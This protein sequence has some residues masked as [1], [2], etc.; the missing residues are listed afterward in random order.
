MLVPFVPTTDSNVSNTPFICL[1][2]LTDDSNNKNTNPNAPRVFFP[3]NITPIPIPP[4]NCTQRGSH[5]PPLA[6][7]IDYLGLLYP[8]EGD[9]SPLSTVP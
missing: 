5:S 2:Q 1:A 8:D 9:A 3:P 4:P 6:P 7:P